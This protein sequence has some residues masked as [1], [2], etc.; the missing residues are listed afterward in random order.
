MMIPGNPGTMTMN[1]PQ[2]LDFELYEPSDNAQVV[3]ATRK[4][5]AQLGFDESEQ[6][7]IATAV[8]ELATNII[9]YANR[10]RITLGMIREDSRTGIEVTAEDYGPGIANID[11]A[12]QEHFSSGNGLGLG[13]PSVRRIMDE[14]AIAS[15][16]GQ[17][18]RIVVRKWR[19]DRLAAVDYYLVKRGMTGWD[20]ECGDTGLVREIGDRCFLALID[21]LGHGKEAHETALLAEHYLSANCGRDLVEVMQGLHMHLK[22]T[23]GV[24]AACCMLNQRSGNLRYVGVGNITSKIYGD[25]PYH[26]VPQDGI[27]GYKMASPTEQQRRLHHGD[28]LL[29]SSDGIREHFDIY[30]FPGLLSGSARQIAT[31]IMD[32]LGKANDDASCL[33]LRYGK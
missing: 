27:V 12:M 6:F 32:N 33:V 1:V 17:G 8:S 20:D 5:A 22:G 7:L 11:E 13:L 9:R 26:F 30:D 21:A 3:Y 31:A 10:G 23:R 14:F 19:G 29:L 16:P 4:L 18:T 24:V 25:H 2:N 15:K 28:I